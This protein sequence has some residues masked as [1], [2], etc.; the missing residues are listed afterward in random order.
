MQKSKPPKVHLNPYNY[1]YAGSF[2]L[3]VKMF[4]YHF[5]FRIQYIQ[6]REIIP[7]FQ[8]SLLKVQYC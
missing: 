5:A 1:E 7:Y 4:I 8:S 2:L 6:R 3:L